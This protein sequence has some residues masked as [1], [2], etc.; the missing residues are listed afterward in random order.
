MTEPGGEFK[1]ERGTDARCKR[2][3][4]G[5]K[6][7]LSS[8][9]SAVLNGRKRGFESDVPRA[10]GFLT[11]EGSQSREKTINGVERSAGDSEFYSLNS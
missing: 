2:T 6:L 9:S 1:T 7:D 11:E 3:P 10:A 5:C 8:A 4:L